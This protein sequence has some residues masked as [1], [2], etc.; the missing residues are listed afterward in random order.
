MKFEDLP[1]YQDLLL[2]DK[3]GFQRIGRITKKSA[4]GNYFQLASY[5]N[6]KVFAVWNFENVTQAIPVSQLLGEQS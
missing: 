3:D 5:E 2:V 6:R 1:M 4:Q